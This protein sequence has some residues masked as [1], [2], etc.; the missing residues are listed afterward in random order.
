MAQVS[1]RDLLKAGV[2]FGH[3]TR[4]WNPKMGKYIFGA[5]NKIHIINLEHTVPALNDALKLVE[6]MAARN[7]KVL[8]VGT[9]R[10]AGKIMKEQAERSSMPFVAHRWLGGMLTNYKTIRQSIK[11]LRDL[12]AQQN[13]GTFEQ[14]TKKEALMRT[15]E[16]E[17]LERSIGGIKEMGGLP[18]VLFVID[19]D[20]ERIAVQEANKLGIPVIGVVDTNS[21]P[22]GIDYVIPGNDDA[23]RAIQIYASAIA[24]AVLEGKQQNGVAADEFVEVAEEAP[25]QEAAE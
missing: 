15:R 21:N 24:D 10:A 18:D 12:E 16:M 11:R 19:V 3:Q 1:M 7:N 2:H 25:A 23:I 17:K 5:R 6:S 4:Y 20:H 22:D 8:F 14:L 9:K 13:D